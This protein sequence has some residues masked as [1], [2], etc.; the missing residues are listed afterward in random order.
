M[1]SVLATSQGL[2]GHCSWR[3]GIA[4]PQFSSVSRGC[5]VGTRTVSISQTVAPGLVL[6]RLQLDL[7]SVLL[8]HS[9]NQDRRQLDKDSLPS[10][11]K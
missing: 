1:V 2:C 9:F 10:S 5:F 6:L 3:R 11:V 7:Y 4:S 8:S